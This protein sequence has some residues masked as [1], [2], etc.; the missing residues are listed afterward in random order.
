MIDVW[1]RIDRTHRQPQRVQLECEACGDVGID[2]M[3]RHSLR[4]GDKE[5]RVLCLDCWID[6]R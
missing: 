3:R 6:W 2:V 5:S 1:S 4:E